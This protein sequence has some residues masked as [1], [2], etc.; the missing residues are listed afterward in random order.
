MADEKGSNNIP[1]FKSPLADEL[2]EQYDKEFDLS[3]RTD[4][5]RKLDGEV[6]KHHPYAL[7]WYLPC[8]RILYWNKFGMPEN[9]LHKYEDWRAVFSNWWV[10]PEKAAKLK[11]ARSSGDSI[12]PIPP[13]EIR[14]WSNEESEQVR[15][16]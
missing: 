6:F 1:G 2:I 16:N 5:L 9:V 15:A 12:R 3:N 4:L 14:P 13:L 10:D 7:E 11:T 8:Q